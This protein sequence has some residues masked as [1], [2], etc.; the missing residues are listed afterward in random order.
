MSPDARRDLVGRS[1]ELLQLRALLAAARRGQGG[2]IVVE[3]APGVGKTAL[4][5]AVRPAD[6]LVLEVTGVESELDLAF[7]ALSE[8]LAP[9][10]DR[11]GTLAP[12]QRAALRGAL[13]LDAP[14]TG[15]RGV[16]LHAVAAVLRGLA[17]AGPVVVLVDD[18]QWLD[19]PSGEAVAFV[20]RRAQRLGVAV[21]VVRSL[22]GAPVPSWPGVDV[23]ALGELDRP[24]A[25]ELVGAR[26]V[27]ATVAGALYDALGGNALALSQAP[28]LLDAAQRAGSAP[29]PE[30]PPT[31]ERLLHAWSARMAGLGSGAT[32]ALLLLALSHDGGLTPLVEALRP[33]GG[34]AG[35]MAAA[36]AGLVTLDARE[37]RFT[38][39]MVR[40]AV[41]SQS[42]PSALLAGHQALAATTTEPARAWHEAAAAPGP[43]EALA[44]RLERLGH[45]A[46]ARGA[47]AT[48][49]RALERAAAISPAASA[50][51]S[52]T[53]AAAAMAISAGRP[54]HAKALL[55]AVLPLA[56]DRLVHADIQLLRGVAME[57]TG[58]PMAAYVLLE[59]EAEAVAGLDPARAAG[60]LTQAGVALV[61]HG[62]MERLAALAQRAVAL[63]GPG[64]DL[65]PAVLHAS[66][67]ASL[68][69]HARAGRLLAGREAALAEVDATAPGH[70]L[71][72][73]VALCHV[74]MEDYE[75]AERSLVALVETCRARG[76]VGPLAL[77]LSVLATLQLRRGFWT[78]AGALADEAAAL[79][80]EAIGHFTHTLAL[81]A[82][83]FVAAHRG[84]EA[85]CVAAAE[86]ARGI[87]LRLE[88][89]STLA[90]AERALGFLA[91]GLGDEEGAIGHLERASEQ[92]RRFGCR[93]PSFLYT[94]ADLAEA[95]E[96]V[97]RRDDAQAVVEALAD[98]ARRTGGAWAAAAT[99]RCRGLVGSDAELDGHLAAALSAHARVAMP[100]ELAR[101]QLCFGERLRRA[102][103]RRESRELLAAAHETFHA[104]GARGWARR[105]ELELAATGERRSARS[106][107]A[108][109][110]TPREREVCRLVAGGATNHEA[111]SALYV[112]PRT[113]EHHLRMA[114]RK[115]GVRSRSELARRLGVTD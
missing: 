37:A 85:V 97:G 59:A 79:G 61:A 108:A 16:V 51:C 71:L 5:G 65:A 63:A 114:Y 8:L 38:H 84:D 104:L 27:A 74:Y 105:A 78:E 115:L 64:A 21:I 60:M 95:Y 77:P 111:A 55:D 81:A 62:T 50:R 49:A 75:Q 14:V 18:V 39:P 46:G 19:G 102:R 48:A 92:T 68:G 80:E 36:D 7:A 86:E 98:G 89:T 106:A 41:L 91:L 58:R 17:D 99:A 1:D 57:Q 112:S 44:A 54:A 66:A 23:M 29:L 28:G 82:V 40:T 103:R 100:F 56:G 34:L 107:D 101:T 93:D 90:C 109:Q 87:A 9:V 10:L 67:L 12:P 4:L 26:G 73:V 32:R 45:E 69:D 22:R 113:V 76:A 43:D 70:E 24:A 2:A 25:L 35:L 42:S 53:L 52:R 20:A 3:G 11:L 15:D 47:P 13:G 6:A 96:R 94:D 88:L 110:L 31:P 33:H 72:S 83:A 30:P